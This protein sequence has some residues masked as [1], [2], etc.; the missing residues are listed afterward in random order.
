MAWSPERE[1][2]KKAAEIA[3]ESHP[4]GFS[5]SQ[6]IDASHKVY[7]GFGADPS[8]KIETLKDVG[9]AANAMAF[10]DG[11]YPAG[12]S[13]CFTVGINGGFGYE[14]PVFLNGDCDEHQEEMLLN[15]IRGMDGP[16]DPDEIAEIFES[17][18]E[19]MAEFIEEQA[20]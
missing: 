15:L 8:K 16:D 14:C 7:G 18:G 17:V 5:K 19:D 13:G 3:R 1:L 10:I 12:L 2:V 4:D 9:N 11:H 20:E 6:L